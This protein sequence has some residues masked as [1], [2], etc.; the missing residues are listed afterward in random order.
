MYQVPQKQGHH[1]Q[2]KLHPLKNTVVRI[3]GPSTKEA[4]CISKIL[5]SIIMFRPRNNFIL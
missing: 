5:A 4:R 3:P 2:R 1:L